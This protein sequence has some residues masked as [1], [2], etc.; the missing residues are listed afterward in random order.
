M[1][2]KV[3]I[4]AVACALVYVAA[5]FGVTANRRTTYRQFTPGTGPGPDITA[6]EFRG[7]ISKTDSFLF[8]LFLPLGVIE[9]AVT[10][11]WYE[12]KGYGLQQAV[13]SPEQSDGAATQESAR[14]AAP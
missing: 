13:E 3:I 14:S 8:H 2:K 7:R 1:K 12:N 5:Y 11:H 6:V 10:G 4:A 9:E